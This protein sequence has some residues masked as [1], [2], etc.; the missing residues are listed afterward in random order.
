[1]L[2]FIL[3]IFERENILFVSIYYAFYFVLL[4]L[5]NIF[6]KASFE[7]LKGFELIYSYNLDSNYGCLIFDLSAAK[8]TYTDV[9]EASGFYFHCVTWSLYHEKQWSPCFNMLLF[10]NKPFRLSILIL[11]DICW[12]LHDLKIKNQIW[13]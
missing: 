11:K 13:S 4:W 8:L 5:C 9:V 1:M 12:M 6:F 10:T 2:D 3:W 7:V